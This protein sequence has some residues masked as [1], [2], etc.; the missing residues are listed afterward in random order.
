MPGNAGGGARREGAHG[1]SREGTDGALRRGRPGNREIDS[2]RPARNLVDAARPYHFLQE[3]EA[4]PFGVETVNTLFLTGKECAFKCLMCDLWKNTLEGP[5]PPGA[6][7]QQIDYALSRLP[8]ADSIKLYNSSN[9]FDP[10]AVPVADYP[11]ILSRVRGYR[12]VI[13]ENHPKLVG[14]A[15]LHFRD[16]L[17][18]D[19]PGGRG[20]TLEIAMGL[21]TIHP[22]ALPAMNKQLTP[23]DFRRAASFLV[24]H[25]IRVRAFVLLNPPFITDPREG[26]RWAVETVRYAFESG[27]HCCSIIATRPGNGIMETLQ[28]AGDYVPPTLDALEEVFATALERVH[29]AGGAG[30]FD[31]GD[32]AV[33]SGRRLVF[34]DTWDI[35]FLSSCPDCFAA[36][37]DRLDAMNLT[38]TIHPPIACSCHA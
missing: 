33:S 16:G 23:A 35:G 36:R 28:R 30:A 25:G 14:D 20:G 17:H 34:V 21:E 15:C 10:K 6:I 19:R 2:L 29:A 38:Q 7:V 9:F 3:R 8:A 11:A 22:V 18:G 26:V 4:V 5:T 12:R 31:P 13:V 1:A 24:S 37:K 32:A 27:T